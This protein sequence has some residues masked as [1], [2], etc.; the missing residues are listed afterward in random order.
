MRF[1]HPEFLYALFAVL[2]PV[3][4]HFFNFRRYKTVFYSDIRFLQDVKRET[5]SRSQLKHLLILL[6][7][8]LF[9]ALLVLAFAQ[10]YFTD[11]ATQVNVEKNVVAIYIDNSFSTELNGTRGQI[12]E[13][14]KNQAAAILKAYPENTKFL[15]I[16]NRIESGFTIELSA[17]EALKKIQEITFSGSSSKINEIN[18]H[19]LDRVREKYNSSYKKDFYFLSD[20]Q[21]SG[22]DIKTFEPDSGIHYYFTPFEP[23]QQANISVDS[24]W[25][26]NPGRP[27]GKVEELTV[28]FTN[29]SDQDYLELPVSLYIND[30]LKSVANID[31]KAGEVE[32][33][34]L[35]FTNPS[36]GVVHGKVGIEDYPVSFD[37]TSYFSYRVENQLKVLRIG[38][39]TSNPYLEAM[40]GVEAYFRFDNVD[41]ASINYS[42]LGSYP[43]VFLDGLSYYSSALVDIIDEQV[44]A[45]SLFIFLPSENENGSSASTLFSKLAA[46]QFISHDTNKVAL[47]MPDFS[48]TFFKN[49]LREKQDKFKLPVVS[50]FYKTDGSRE[51]S[52]IPVLSSENGDPLLI[53]YHL[54]NG[55]FMQFT[56]PFTQKNDEVLKHPV[57]LPLIFNV[58]LQSGRQ[59]QLAYT[60]QPNLQLILN[61]FR[62]EIKSGLLI[63]SRDKS[64]Q[65]IPD[66]YKQPGNVRAIINDRDLEAGNYELF[67]DNSLLSGLALNYS[68]KES[69]M[70]FYS[71]DDIRNQIPETQQGFVKVV[72]PDTM[73]SGEVIGSFGNNDLWK[74]FVSGAILAI[75]MEILLIL[76]Y[77]K[78]FRP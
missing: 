61:E 5:R 43:L 29:Y 62:S 27:A 4:I 26:E 23:K 39:G 55:N 57:L 47:A 14:E 22:S 40:F 75:L 17:D 65:L 76:F 59:L 24:C 56:F 19:L 10:P 28:Q 71:A 64:Y 70:S 51:I 46:K 66:L 1:I 53:D 34:K 11:S 48:S 13:L 15:L 50:E 77:D 68:R 31:L 7:R 74:Y 78:I 44:Q 30:S 42:E 35:S 52:A 69:D 49:A 36:E 21:K 58:A 16:T 25:F 33:I 41:E 9:I 73:D 37:N 2:I 45:G 12:L 67:S 6:S 18:S 20:F 60:I 72:D 63:A 8:M 54:G 32:R 38:T 3:I